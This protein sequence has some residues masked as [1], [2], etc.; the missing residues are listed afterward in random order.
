M[1]DLLVLG[2]PENHKKLAD[3]SFD[4]FVN[5]ALLRNQVID[6][7][8]LGFKARKVSNAFSLVSV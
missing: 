3:V 6:S 8:R 5:S 7:S 2:F 4:H 1:T